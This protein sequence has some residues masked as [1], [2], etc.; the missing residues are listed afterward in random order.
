MLIRNNFQTD[1]IKL[2]QLC[3][4]ERRILTAIDEIS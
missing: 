2:N 4:E 3:I 1:V